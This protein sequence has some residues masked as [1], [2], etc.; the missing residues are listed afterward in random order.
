[1]KWKS[2]DRTRR[3]WNNNQQRNW[4]NNQQR[5]WNKNQQ[6]NWN[7]NQQRN[8][9]NN[10]QRNCFDRLESVLKG[11]RTNLIRCHLTKLTSCGMLLKS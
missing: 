5:N 11:V 7:K 6:R 1:M 8:W 4:N 10:Q 2:F 9:N 3:N